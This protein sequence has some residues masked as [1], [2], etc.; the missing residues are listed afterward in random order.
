MMMR[1]MHIRLAARNLGRQPHR[2]I[3]LGGAVAFS[4]LVMNL[5]AGFV[6]GMDAAVQ[7]NV[8]LYA[9]GHVLVSAY[10]VSWSGRSQ[11]RAT[12]SEVVD[13]VRQV[14]PEVRSA[15]TLVQTRA[16]MVF[17]SRELQMILRGIDW[18]DDQ[19]YRTMLMLKEGNWNSAGI[20]RPMVLSAQS[21]ERFGLALGDEVLVR[22]S[23]AS[24]QQNV[25]E[26][27]VVA[28]YD[29]TAAGGLHAAFVRAEDLRAD[30]NMKEHEW[31]SVAVFLRDG[32]QAPSGASIL[33]RAM[34]RQGLKLDGQ[35]RTGAVAGSVS[36]RISTLQDLAGEV[37]SALGAI[38]WIGYAVFALMLAVCATGIANSFRMVLLERTREIGML[39]C[40]GF[41]K[42][43]VFASFLSEGMLLAGGAALAGI[44]ASIPLGLL[45]SLIP[46]DPHGDFGAALVKGHLLF[47][48]SVVQM[49]I[50][51][52]CV[53]IAAILTVIMPAR[54]AAAIAPADALRV[55]A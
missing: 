39:R 31:Q 22:M 26:Y 30:L 46:F 43:D 9:G 13:L 14:V 27:R 47:M 44:L 28:I 40:I 6:N 51:L 35:S 4:A 36:Y 34:E 32:A 21:A 19:L 8:T 55:T 48:P 53:T 17:G 23:T 50:V 24:G 15:T 29:E 7:N 54:R 1:K 16:T 10:T 5:I 33:K 3:A 37:G 2:T 11:N 41:K 52:V 18:E 42:K 45:L 49:L 25:T 20:S 12:G 38:R